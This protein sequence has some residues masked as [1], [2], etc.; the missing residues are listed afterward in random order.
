MRVAFATDNGTE[1][2]KEH[3]GSARYYLIYEYDE[4]NGTLKFIEKVENLTGEEEKHGDEKKAKN[5]MEFMERLGVK[6]FVGFAMG[7]NIVFIRKRFVPVISRIK[8][9]E[10]AIKKIDMEIVE[11]EARKPEGIERNIVYIKLS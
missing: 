7:P 3:F 4:K 2:T 1:F 10:E 9:I 6:A 11:K 5:V 8:K